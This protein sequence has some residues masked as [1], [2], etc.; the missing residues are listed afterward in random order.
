MFLGRLGSAWEVLN[1]VAIVSALVE[2]GL[3]DGQQPAVPAALLTMCSAA[4]LCSSPQPSSPRPQP[5][6]PAGPAPALDLVSL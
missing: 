2:W 1:R 4:A 6:L 3:L 5:A